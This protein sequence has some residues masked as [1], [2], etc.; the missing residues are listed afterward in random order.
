M[1]YVF[2]KR[3]LKQDNI[4]IPDETVFVAAEH[5][6]SVDKLEW[7]YVPELTESAQQAFD[8]IESVMPQV[9]YKA[10]LERLANLPNLNK[11]H[12]DPVAAAYQYASDWSEIRPEWG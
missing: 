1:Q 4:N 6:T 9:S 2:C 12:K 5:K 8:L 3:R 7:I 11:E 10:N